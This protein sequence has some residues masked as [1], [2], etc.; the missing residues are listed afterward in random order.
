MSARTQA[1]DREV[2]PV[3]QRLRLRYAKRGR[4]RF[5]SHRDFQRALERAIRRAGLPIAYSA[6]FSPHPKISYAGAA[7]TGSASEAEY[8]EIGLTEPC[9]PEDVRQALDQALPDGLDVL[10]V[11]PAGSTPLAERLQASDWRIELEGISPAE[12]EAAVDRFL[13]LDE[14]PVERLTKSGR[15][16]FDARGAVIRLAV[17]GR[18]EPDAASCA[19]L[20]LVV[21]HETPAV[22]PDDVLNGL[23]EAAGL[24]PPVTPRVIRLAQ[25][26]WNEESGAVGDPLAADR[27]AAATG[28]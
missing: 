13:A 19:I 4:M 11:V 27:D 14:V 1:P 15:R 2:L 22:R 20:R 12:A 3:V 24:V 16:R 8:A 17:T 23:R 28:E 6:G 26:P 5:G 18:Q 10:A 25:G 9:D 7:P 21:R